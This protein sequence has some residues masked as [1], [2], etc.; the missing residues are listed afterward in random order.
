M[1]ILMTGGWMQ[2]QL[3]ETPEAMGE[4]RNS[5]VSPSNHHAS[6]VHFGSALQATAAL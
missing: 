5:V 1:K 6:W 3:I 2:M 4:I